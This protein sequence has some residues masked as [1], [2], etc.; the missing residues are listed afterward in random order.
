MRGSE[1]RVTIL[2]VGRIGQIRDVTRDL[3][4]RLATGSW[5]NV[6]TTFARTLATSTRISLRALVVLDLI[7]GGGLGWTV[8]RARDQRDAVA[9]IQHAGGTVTYDWEWTNGKC[10][11][12]GEPIWPKWLVERLGVDYFGHVVGVNLFHGSDAELA[13]IPTEGKPRNKIAN[14]VKDAIVHRS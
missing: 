4:M 1:R 3:G 8:Y 2:A 5:W 6:R 14:P 10:N 11:P 13:W 7:T 9:A 12:R